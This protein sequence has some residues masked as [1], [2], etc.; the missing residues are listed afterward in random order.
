MR[1]CTTIAVTCPGR[2]AAPKGRLRGRLRTP[3][4]RASY[5]DATQ[6]RDPGFFTS[7]DRGPASAVQRFALHRVRDTGV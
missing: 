5:G 2:G 7:N 6:T 1:G 4:L 3:A